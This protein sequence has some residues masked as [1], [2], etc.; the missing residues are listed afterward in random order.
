MENCNSALR[1]SSKSDA[2]TQS[3]SIPTKT[4]SNTDTLYSCSENEGVLSLMSK[5]VIFTYARLDCDGMPMST[6]S[7]NSW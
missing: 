3:I 6:A 7:T 2:E 4:S 1:P 5:M